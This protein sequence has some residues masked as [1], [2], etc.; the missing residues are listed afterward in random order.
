LALKCIRTSEMCN[1]AWVLSVE[2]VRMWHSFD[3]FDIVWMCMLC[4][5]CFNANLDHSSVGFV[6]DFVRYVWIFWQNLL[7]ICIALE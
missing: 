4:K 6:K 3:I 7:H 2:G 5:D 1:I